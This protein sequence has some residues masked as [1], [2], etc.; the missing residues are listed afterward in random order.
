MS[1]SAEQSGR[2]P[3]GFKSVSF[4]KIIV[5]A[6]VC[7]LVTAALPVILVGYYANKA[8]ISG[9]GND[10]IEQ[11]SRTVIERTVNHFLP[12]SIAVEMSSRLTQLGA[13]SSCDFK[14]TEMYTLGVLKSY[15]QVSMFYLADEQG[16]YVRA[17]RLS[18][19]TTE[20]RI[21]RTA[22]SP[23][24]DLFVYRDAAFEVA[25]I[26]ESHEIDYNPRVRPWYVGA[27]KTKANFWTDVYVL[28][29]NKKPAITSSHP[30]FDND[31]KFAGVW[32]MDIE[33]EEI[34]DF[35]KTQKIGKSGI[36]LIINEKGEIVA[37]P[38]P[39]LIIREE[40][41]GL[42]PVTV[43]EFGLEPL[44]A[45]YRQHLRTGEARAVVECKGTRYLASFTEFPEPFPMRWKVGVL[46][47]ENDF[48]GGAKQTMITMLLISSVM[49]VLAVI[50]ALFVS[51]SISSPVR[52]IAEA[53]AKI[54]NFNLDGKIDIPSSMKEI[55]LM[56]DAVSSM[57]KGL[58]AFRRYVPSELV[59][60]LISTGEGA[61]LGGR[62]KEMT[63]MFSDITGFTSIAELMSPEEL[64]LHLSEYF[65]ELTRIVTHHKGTVDKYIGDA[66]M[67]FWGA[68]INDDDH[69][70]HACEAGLACQEK[71]AELN[72][73]WAE[74]G[75]S[76]FI[77]RIGIST[78]PTLVGNVGS[79]ERM[80]YTVMGDN[81]NM[82]SRLE[83]AN[84]F[85]GTQIIVAANTYEAASKEFLFR[86]LGIAAVKGKSEDQ[87]IYELVGKKHSKES[88]EKS[89]T[90]LGEETAVS[91]STASSGHCLSIDISEQ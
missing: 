87:K 15:P 69:A 50:P 55:Q 57:Q 9:L 51:R 11:T 68:P 23:P 24:T 91:Q 34:S 4:Y 7:L 22:A 26:Q 40:N 28:F 81:V 33:L 36:E 66:V 82:A 59:R 83:E 19:G 86:P 67:A 25:D 44:S 63:V 84:K 60:Q 75:K 1:E 49:L 17:W 5:F 73:K 41:G 13:I 20:S 8:I 78:G 42:R 27:K 85:Y 14:Q 88:K 64:M 74:E 32:A 10:L 37:Y 61:Q 54:K 72:R 21:I 47:P 43:E 89:R 58:H 16:N 62:K 65:D 38:D 76:V 35:L 52:L 90:Q 56:R 48:L 80:N 3:F 2:R 39:S 12:A 79:T 18:D 53:T 30:L 29:R 70:V 6:F 77:T 45:A 31:G 71:I 46:V